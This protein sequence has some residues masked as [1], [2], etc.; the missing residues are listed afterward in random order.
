MPRSDCNGFCVF[1][2]KEEEAEE[3]DE[4]AANPLALFSLIVP[5]AYANKGH[6]H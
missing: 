2:E 4:A 5:L 6:L 1:D 3:E